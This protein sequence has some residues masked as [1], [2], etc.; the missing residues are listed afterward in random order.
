MISLKPGY[1]NEY[2]MGNKTKRHSRMIYPIVRFIP[3]NKISEY[4]AL[5]KISNTKKGTKVELFRKIKRVG[6]YIG[7]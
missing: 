6:R 2:K 3:G 4:F 5:E 1:S 7:L